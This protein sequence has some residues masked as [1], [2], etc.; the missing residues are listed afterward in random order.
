MSDAT[1]VSQALLEPEVFPLSPPTQAGQGHRAP[2]LWISHSGS[3]Q[4]GHP[5]GSRPTLG[6]SP[7]SRVPLRRLP[8]VGRTSE[9]H[10]ADRGT[11]RLHKLP[12]KSRSSKAKCLPRRFPQCAGV[13]QFPCLAALLGQRSR[14]SAHFAH[15]HGHELVQNWRNYIGVC[16]QARQCLP[17]VLHA[18]MGHSCH[19]VHA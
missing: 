6:G 17:A 3:W 13:L 4:S 5:L 10:P 18:I 19:A 15:F 8:P 11:S 16:L 7:V 9:G 1:A 14:R 2:W 12:G